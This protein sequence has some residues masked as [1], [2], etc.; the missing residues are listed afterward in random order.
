M[1][2]DDI[3]LRAERAAEKLRQL[4]A[5]RGPVTSAVDE[6]GTR[7]EGGV[8]FL[9]LEPPGEEAEWAL[10]CVEVREQSIATGHAS[11]TVPP[12]LSELARQIPAVAQAVARG[13]MFELIGPASV[14]KGLREGAMELIPSKTGGL[15]GGVRKVGGKKIIY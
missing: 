11:R 5:A 13:E 4:Q 12:L 14:L 6:G 10:S 15:I 7:S 9:V 8:E 2:D 3:F 1:S